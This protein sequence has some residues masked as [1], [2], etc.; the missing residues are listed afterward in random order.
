MSTTLS[1][2]SGTM[3]LSVSSALSLVSGTMSLSALSLVFGMMSSSLA[4]ELLR[5][6]RL[7]DACIV[8]CIASAQW[9]LPSTAPCTPDLRASKC[10]TVS[11]ADSIAGS[12]ISNH[13][14]SPGRS[15]TSRDVNSSSSSRNTFWSRA[16]SLAHCFRFDMLCVWFLAASHPGNAVWE[17]V[18]CGKSLS[19]GGCGT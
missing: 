6:N 1:L 2:V 13:A 11:V 8:D 15:P 18:L 5:A 7:V 14:R 9:S 3:P 10:T 17:C 19:A 4:G 16:S 12:H